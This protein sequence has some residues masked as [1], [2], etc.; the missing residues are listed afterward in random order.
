MRRLLILLLFIP[1]FGLS[2]TWPVKHINVAGSNVVTKDVDGNVSI[3]GDIKIG[4]VSTTTDGT[5]RWT[6]TDFEGYDGSGWQS[7]TTGIDDQNISGSS[8]NDTNNY[9]TIGIEDGGSETIGIP[10]YDYWFLGANGADYEPI[11]G[12]YYVDFVE[13]NGIT[14][15]KDVDADVHT[16]NISS[17]VSG[18]YNDGGCILTD[19]TDGEIYNALN[20]Y[21]SSGFSLA[22]GVCADLIG[23]CYNVMALQA[24]DSTSFN[25]IVADQDTGDRQYYPIE[26]GSTNTTFGKV[27]IIVAG[28]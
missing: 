5:I 9:L 22:T 14:I 18:G 24:V 7:F 23:E 12:K 3:A 10:V 19:P 1:M 13:G 21:V 4:N 15:S 28:N 27:N 20:S 8:W 16:I 25:I 11:H 2:Q 6:G 26:D 17:D